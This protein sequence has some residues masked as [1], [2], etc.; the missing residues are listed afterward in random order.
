MVTWPLLVRPRRRGGISASTTSPRSTVGSPART[1]HARG[2][3]GSPPGA[4]RPRP[5][6][7]RPGP[8][9]GRH[10]PDDRHSPSVLRQ[11]WLLTR[12]NAEVLVRNRLTLAILLGSPV[13]VTAMMAVLFRPG[14]FE[15]PRRGRHRAG[16]DRLLGGL[17][18]F[19]SASPTDCS[20]SSGSGPSSGANTFRVQRR[21]LRRGQGRRTGAG[22]GRGDRCSPRRAAR[23][24]PAS[25]HG[26]GRVHVTAGLPAGGGGVG[27]GSRPA[28]LG[29]CLQCRAGRARPADAVLPPGALRRRGCSRRR[30][31]GSRALAQPGPGQ[32]LLVRGTG[33]CPGARPARR[34]AS[35]HA[36]LR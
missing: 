8:R 4:S 36:R 17:S 22:A 2:R 34:R 19:S 1:R 25:R 30:H 20:R 10:V 27:A 9:P 33:A 11:W 29:G 12:R 21:R 15:R 7:G 26:L 31:G 14:A 13:L 16:P 24:R 18:G 3:S 35:G 6:P 32:P 23:A 28:G 5:R